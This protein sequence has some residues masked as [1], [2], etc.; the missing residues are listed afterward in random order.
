MDESIN[1]EHK[2]KTL[3]YKIVDGLLMVVKIFGYF[4]LMNN[5]FK[6]FD[7]THD[8]NTYTG[9]FAFPQAT[10]DDGASGEP[11]IVHACS[12]TWDT[13]TEWQ[14][15]DNWPHVF[16]LILATLSFALLLPS[17]LSAS[18]LLQVINPDHSVLFQ[19]WFI[20]L[21]IT[22]LTMTAGIKVFLSSPGVAHLRTMLN[23]V[24]CVC[25]VGC[26]CQK[27]TCTWKLLNQVMRYVFALSGLWSI[28][29]LFVVNA[30]VGDPFAQWV[31]GFVEIS[32]IVLMLLVTFYMIFPLR[33]F[34]NVLMPKKASSPDAN[35]T[36]KGEKTSSNWHSAFQKLRFIIPPRKVATLGVHPG[37]RCCPPS[38]CEV[39]AM[40]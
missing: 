6:A 1:S 16:T 19:G 36:E 12:M 34:V 11:N 28:C 33:L 37:T 10:A 9:D 20:R 40:V 7:C 39:K 22:A 8:E 26:M 30:P 5:I 4:P 25:L 15:Y 23:C 38:W 2:K 32:L 29:A 21:R 31:T 27:N 14:C 17:V 35:P 18:Q 24:V 3:K 13:Y